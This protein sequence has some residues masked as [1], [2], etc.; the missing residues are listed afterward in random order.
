MT[1][2]IIDQY[3]SHSSNFSLSNV[4]DEAARDTESL[5]NLEVATVVCFMV[6]VWQIAM[7]LF[8][9]GV[10]GIIL[11]DH[12]VS[13]FT[14]GAAIHVL[15]SQ[16]K[17]LLGIQ[18]PRFNGPFR[19]IRSY[20][21]IFSVLPSAN[22]A[23]VISSSIAILCLALHNDWL[24]PWYSKKM[25][26]PV[27][28]ELLILV[29]GTLASSYC[30]LSEKYNI[31]ILEHIPTGLPAP[32]LP[33]LSLIPNML[34]ETLIVA[35]VAYAVSLSMA[36]IF[37]RKHEYQ[38]NN[39]QEL[40]AQGMSNLVA[41]FFSCMP[42]SASL[43]RS[44]LQEVAGGKTQ[45]ASVVSCA[46]LSIVMLWVGPLFESLPLSV[47]ASVIIVTLKG[48]FLQ[49][50]NFRTTLSTSP[51]DA[52][53]WLVTFLAVVIIDIDIGLGFGVVASISVLIYRGH[54]PHAAVLGL[55]PGTEIYVDISL[56]P[57]AVEESGIKVFRWVGAIHFANEETF[58]SVLEAHLTPK[59]FLPPIIGQL[60]LDKEAT[61]DPFSKFGSWD[62]AC[63]EPLKSSSVQIGALSTIEHLICDCSA[64]S[65]IDLSAS[66][67]LISL[68]ADLESRCVRLVM[69]ACS[70]HLIQQLERCNYFQHFPKS[71]VYPSIIDAVLSIKSSFTVGTF[72][73]RN[74]P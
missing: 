72:D 60:E 28:I 29:V 59:K 53:I 67:M 7:G 71:R 51:L 55:L 22:P 46:L 9:L 19:L 74:L 11:S 56:Y 13:G 40:L 4:S 45:I 63:S 41:S 30:N 15:T 36:K 47:L 35:V 12:L 73:A 31:Q 68:H 39:N 43:S 8:R 54:Y 57:T 16:I 69:A 17:N 37:S 42:V 44:L 38:I 21:S 49:V 70:N 23:D 25:K 52:V 18:V 5:T 24:K 48:M 34:L 6:G 1:G 26:Y 20:Q 27:P 65:Y 14:T 66:R 64:L 2:R 32:R 33:P 62:Q 61:N 50:T 10:V 3:R 58:R